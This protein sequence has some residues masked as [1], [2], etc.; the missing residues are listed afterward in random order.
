M[1]E[2][3]IH[4]CRDCPQFIPNFKIL[5]EHSDNDLFLNKNLVFEIANEVSSRASLKNLIYEVA[6]MD[7]TSRFGPPTQ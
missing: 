4:M 2:R 5:F 6:S 7:L 3:G 1:M